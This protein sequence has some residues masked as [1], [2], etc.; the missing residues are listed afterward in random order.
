MWNLLAFLGDRFGSLFHHLL[1]QWPTP[2]A[3]HSSRFFGVGPKGGDE[4]DN[5]WKSPR[6]NTL[7]MA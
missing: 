1:T 7:A 2:F 5:D 3:N 4:K 6:G